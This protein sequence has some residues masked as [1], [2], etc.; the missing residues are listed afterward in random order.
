MAFELIS[1]TDDNKSPIPPYGSDCLLSTVHGR[2]V[3]LSLSPTS[4]LPLEDFSLEGIEIPSL[5]LDAPKDD[6]MYLS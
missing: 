2:G 1:S 3:G 4:S 5:V 6:V